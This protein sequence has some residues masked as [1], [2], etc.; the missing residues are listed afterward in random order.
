MR[1][2]NTAETMQSFI[3]IDEPEEYQTSARVVEISDEDYHAHDAVSKSK[4]AEFYNSPIVYKA[5]YVDKVMPQK[6]A[7]SGMELGTILHAVLLEGK[8]L[9]DLI[10]VLPTTCLTSSGSI[11]SRGSEYKDFAARNTGKVILKQSAIKPISDCV[12]AVLR[13]DLGQVLGTS[14]DKERSIFWTDAETGLECRCKPDFWVELDDHIVCYDLKISRMVNKESFRRQIKS[15]SYWMQDAHYSEGLSKLTGKPVQ[16]RFWVVEPVQPYRV[17]C[18][19]LEENITRIESHKR[20]RDLMDRF[21]DAQASGVYS[22]DLQS[23]IVLNQWDFG[24]EAESELEMK[25]DE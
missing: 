17:A 23:A 21:A 6:T 1:R 2:M 19:W 3:L 5:R 25:W 12:A 18:Y 20:W 16:F 9:D 8:R 7:T 14:K 11:N 13:S 10:A 15:F 24:G 4:L 22:E